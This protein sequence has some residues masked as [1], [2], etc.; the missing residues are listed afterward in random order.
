MTKATLLIMA[1]AF[2][3][4][5]YA[6]NK[7]LHQLEI[8]GG[9]LIDQDDQRIPFLEDEF[10]EAYQLNYRG[11]QYLAIGYTRTKSKTRLGI[12]IDYFKYGKL[13][14][15]Y[16]RI[17]GPTFPPGRYKQQIQF[18]IFYGRSII[19]NSKLNLYIA[20]IT[21]IAFRKNTLFGGTLV[22][23]DTPV[24]DFVIA[25]GGKLQVNFKVTD[26]ISISLGSKLMVLDYY[27]RNV[28]NSIEKTN[29]FDFIRGETVLQLGLVF[30]L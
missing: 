9:Y 21:S 14:H 15:D 8:K 4:S 25:L 11:L 28:A 6:Q 1:M 26:K 3:L 19:N 27:V 29:H 18:A 10:G 30:N 5:S 12:E 17:S 23:L 16:S 22:D 13:T 7:I 2:A 20:P 24:Q